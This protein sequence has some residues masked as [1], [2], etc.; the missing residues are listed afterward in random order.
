MGSGIGN[1]KFDK[2]GIIL[3]FVYTT[4]GKK[5]EKVTNKTPRGSDDLLGHLPNIKKTTSVYI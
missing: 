2:Q 3:P 1:W 4:V 5:H